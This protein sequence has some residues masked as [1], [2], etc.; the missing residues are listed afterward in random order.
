M[1][2]YNKY[3]VNIKKKAGTKVLAFQLAGL[4]EQDAAGWVGSTALISSAFY[5]PTQLCGEW[6]NESNSN[7]YRFLSHSN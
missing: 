5:S 4:S 2:K 7:Q 6:D 1:I 3:F